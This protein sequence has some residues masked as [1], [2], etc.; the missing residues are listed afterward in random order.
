MKSIKSFIYLDEYKMYSISSQIFEGITESILKTESN[1]SEQDTSQKGPMASGRVMADI[2]SASYKN[3][4]K[5]YLH[6]YAY[7]IFE[8]KIYEN[9][10]VLDV[11]NDSISSFEQDIHKTKFIKITGRSVL[12]DTKAVHELIHY[13]KLLHYGLDYISKGGANIKSEKKTGYITIKIS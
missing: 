6:D 4:E 2:I 9:Q 5:R 8:S 13:F 11:N 10:E 12:N 1:S 3:T 7:N